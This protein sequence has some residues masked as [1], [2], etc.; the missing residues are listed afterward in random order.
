MP[1]DTNNFP[2]SLKNL[3]NAIRNKA[4]DIANAMVEEGYEENQ[5]LPIATKKAKEWYNNASEHEIRKI[6]KAS[7][8]K[9]KSHDNDNSINP[10]LLNKGE[11]VLAH[12]DGWAVQAEDAK[13]PSEVFEK[14][15]DAIARARQIAKNKGTHLIVLT[16][17]GKVQEKTSYQVK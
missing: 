6:E 10:D 7:D 11:H 4:I 12:K 16:R 15:Q 2:S 3:K 8:N 13:Q 9:L 5:A 14:K 17:D 1:W